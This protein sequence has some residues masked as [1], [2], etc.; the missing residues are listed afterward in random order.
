MRV[1]IYQLFG[2][3]F[4]LLKFYTN[5]ENLANYMPFF[6][7]LCRSLLCHLIINFI[8]SDYVK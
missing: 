5:F 3:N 4:V 2:L 1:S 7:V 8:T 6:A